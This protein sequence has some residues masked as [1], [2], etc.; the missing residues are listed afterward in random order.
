[1]NNVQRD[2]QRNQLI[3]Y[4]PRSIALPAL[5]SGYVTNLNR[6]FCNDIPQKEI[7]RQNLTVI[8]PD[9]ELIKKR[10]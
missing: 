5:I 6:R 1:M 9:Q 10:R 7:E 3:P 2:I 4:Y 8:K